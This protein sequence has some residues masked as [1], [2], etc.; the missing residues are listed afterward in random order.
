MTCRAVVP[1]IGELAG[2]GEHRGVRGMQ[3]GPVLTS[4]GRGRVD[5]AHGDAEADPGVGVPWPLPVNMTAIPQE[6]AA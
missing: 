2:G 3:V 6:F 4:C 5:R 1:G